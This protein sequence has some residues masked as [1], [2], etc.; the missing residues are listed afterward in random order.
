M[1]LSLRY[2]FKSV[3]IFSPLSWSPNPTTAFSFC[4]LG[5]D[6]GEVVL[7]ID[8]GASFA[9]TSAFLAA[10]KLVLNEGR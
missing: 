7:E 5:T 8:V 6:D 2:L 9:D 4:E 3:S 10:I 1:I